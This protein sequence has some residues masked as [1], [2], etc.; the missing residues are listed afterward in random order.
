MDD[1]KTAGALDGGGGGSPCRMSILRNA[2]VACLCRLLM[3]ISHVE[4]NKWPC[5]MSNLR[6]GPC[7]C[8]MSIGAMSHV[9]FKK[10]PCRLVNFRGLGPYCSNCM[11]TSCQNECKTYTLIWNTKGSNPGVRIER[12]NVHIISINLCQCIFYTPYNNHPYLIR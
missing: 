5:R 9:G 11:H 12:L 10:W 6:N 1:S 8:H 2:N 7:Q 3:P 4:F